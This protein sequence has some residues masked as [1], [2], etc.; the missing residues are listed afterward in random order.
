VISGFVPG[1]TW[2]FTFKD[3]SITLSNGNFTAAGTATNGATRATISR[4][5]GKYYFEVLKESS[6]GGIGPSI[7]VGT[8]SM[9][10]NAQIGDS[11]TSWGLIQDGRKY[12]SGIPA[13]LASAI[14]NG[15][16]VMIAIDL[17][18]GLLWWGKNGTWFASGDPGAG[19][20]SHYSGVTGT[21]YPA[22]SPGGTGG[23]ATGRFSS[24]SFSHTPPSGFSAW[25]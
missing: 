14:A 18:A 8:S 21:I 1:V 20:G 13:S 22:L 7:G 16:V 19:T 3:S 10:T 5:S 12:H 4:S 2:D 17:D 23:Q 15:D 24:G 11:S 25:Q 9:A 6:G